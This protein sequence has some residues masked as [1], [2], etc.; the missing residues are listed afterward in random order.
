MIEV[1]KHGKRYEIKCVFCEA[2]LRFSEG[3]IVAY[4]TSEYIVC[5]ECKK[6]ICVDKAQ[7]VDDWE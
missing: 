5:P 2:E 4:G 7:I 6:N 3:D 1:I